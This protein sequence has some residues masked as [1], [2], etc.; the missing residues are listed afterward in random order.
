MGE[1]L[2]QELTMPKWG[3]TMTE[4]KVVQWLVEPGTRFSEGDELLEIETEKITG[5]VEAPAAGMLLRQVA[6]LDEEVPVAGL[7]GVIADSAAPDDEIDQFVESFQSSFVPEQAESQAAGP[8]PEWIEVA[9]RSL[10][11][12]KRGESGPPVILLH[13]FGGD[14]NSWLLNH[15]PLAERRT[16][17][18]LDL[19]GHG[20]SDKDV[21]EGTISSLAAAAAGFMDAVGLD[22]AH[23]VGHSLGGAV[24]LELALAQPNRTSSCSLLCPAGLGPEINVDYIDGFVSASRRKQIKPHLEQLFADSALVNRRF[25]DEVL[26]AKRLDGVETALRTIAG[27]FITDGRQAAQYRDRLEEVS[28]PVLIIWGDKDQII[29]ASQAEGLPSTIQRHIINDSGHMVQMESARQVNT[30]IDQF[31]G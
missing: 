29:P 14:L 7:L 21:G 12:L 30:L 24:V 17:Y 19:P 13:G 11:Y 27:K 25:V 26:K 9:G 23:L 2:L 15:Q 6:R 16:V 22:K 18:A 31:L 10:C 4:G 20:R 1:S 8:A 3:L 28:A 5:A